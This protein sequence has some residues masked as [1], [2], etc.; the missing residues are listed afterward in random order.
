MCGFR[1]ANTRFCAFVRSFVGDARATTT[2]DRWMN[3][4]MN[5]S[6]GPSTHVRARVVACTRAAFARTPRCDRHRPPAYFQS[7]KSLDMARERRETSPSATG[8]AIDGDQ[9]PGVPVR[10]RE[11]SPRKSAREANRGAVQRYRDRQR[12]RAGALER[13][14]ARLRETNARLEGELA[15]ARWVLEEV[16]RRYALEESV[17][18]RQVGSG[19]GW[20]TFTIAHGSGCPLGERETARGG[21]F[22][23]VANAFANANGRGSARGRGDARGE[24]ERD[25]E[26]GAMKGKRRKR[27]R[28]GGDVDDEDD[29]AEFLNTFLV[30]DDTCPCPGHSHADSH[31]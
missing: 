7:L 29:L 16:R 20:P 21:P 23:S 6:R 17:R 19:G 3:G 11:Q 1:A 5:R 26:D 14:C 10:A 18:T 30:H 31:E 4:W 25:G 28:G 2:D 13:E 12:A 24:E 8:G 15:H 22:G 9:L 27:R